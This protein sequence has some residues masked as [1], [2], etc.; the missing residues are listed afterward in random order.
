MHGDRLVPVGLRNAV[1]KM[2]HEGGLYRHKGH[3]VQRND[4]RRVPPGQVRK[5]LSHGSCELA[6]AASARGQDAVFKG[7]A[8]QDTVFQ[9]RNIFPQEPLRYFHSD[10]CFERCVG[11]MA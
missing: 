1:L 3:S 6:T 4:C 9:N 10:L 5:R 7:D 8:E 2:V 11:A